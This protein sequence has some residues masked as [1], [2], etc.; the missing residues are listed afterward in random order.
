MYDVLENPD[1]TDVLLVHAEP[2]LPD[3]VVD[4][5]PEWTEPP[6]EA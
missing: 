2:G 1:I 4:P 3:P 5:V 6:E